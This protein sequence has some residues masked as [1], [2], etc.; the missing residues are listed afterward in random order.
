LNVKDITY[1]IREKI[2]FST[3]K[4]PQANFTP[5]TVNQMLENPR[6]YFSGRTGSSNYATPKGT[7]VNFKPDPPT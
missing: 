4:T 5:S 6:L 1:E 7:A 2:T 3:S